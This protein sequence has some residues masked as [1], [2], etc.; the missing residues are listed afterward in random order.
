VLPKVK[1]GTVQPAEETRDDIYGIRLRGSEI[2]LHG[3]G[4][5]GG[6]SCESSGWTGIG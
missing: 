1:E 3:G 5:G 6:L 2:G 4:K